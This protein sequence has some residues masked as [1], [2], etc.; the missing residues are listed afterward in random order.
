MHSVIGK[1]VGAEFGF[2][3]GEEGL[4]GL[5]LC[6]RFGTDYIGTGTDYTMLLSKDIKAT[7]EVIAT[8]SK[9]IVMKIKQ[10]LKDAKVNYISELVDKPVKITLTED[11]YFKDFRI[12]TEI[13]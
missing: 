5:I 6:F 3:P 8:C 1:I 10:S 9:S 11:G 13:L 4:L 12:L 2:Y 7:E